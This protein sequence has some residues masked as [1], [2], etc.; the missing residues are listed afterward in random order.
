MADQAQIIDGKALSKT[1]REEV[2]VRAEAFFAQHGRQ[3]GLHVVL[4]GDREM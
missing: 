3:P 1:V 2:K 4:V